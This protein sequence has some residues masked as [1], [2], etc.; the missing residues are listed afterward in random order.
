MTG[1]SNQPDYG[2][3][4]EAEK[5]KLEEPPQYRVMLINDDYTPM[6]FV[7]DVLQKIFSMNRQQEWITAPKKN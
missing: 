3:V 4:V 6:E 2:L 1:E 5:P 7:V